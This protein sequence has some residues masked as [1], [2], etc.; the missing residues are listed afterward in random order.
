[1]PKKETTSLAEARPDL[2]AEWHPSLNGLV[3][4]EQVLAKSTKK[5]WW[6]CP[7]GD[8][9]EWEARVADRFKRGCHV[10]NGFKVVK[11][12]CLATLNPKLSSEWHPIKNGHRTPFDFSPGSNKKVWW[13]CPEGDDHEWKASIKLRRK[14]GC[15]V[16]AGKMVVNS[17]CLATTNPDL[18]ADWHPSK[19]GELTP[20]D[21][22]EGSDKKVWWK[23]PEGDDHEWE[24]TLKARSIGNGCSVCHGLTV[25]NSNCL[26]TTNPAKAAHWH[27]TKNGDFTPYDFTEFSQQ[28]VWWKC[29]EADDHEWELSIAAKKSN[30][31]PFCTGRLVCSSNSLRTKNAELT[32]QWHATKNGSLTPDDVTEFSSKKIW[33]KCPEGLDHEWEATVYNRKK[34]GCPMCYGKLVSDDNNLEVVAPDLAALWHPTKNGDLKP[35]DVTKGTMRVVWWKCPEGDDHEWKGPVNH[36]YSNFLRDYKTKGCP[37]CSGY[38][39]VESTSLAKVNPGLAKEWHTVKNG[40]TTPEQVSYFSSKK[41][42]WQCQIDPGHFW[43]STVRDR[44]HGSKCPYCSLTPQSKQEL[45]ISF[46]LKS[47]FHDINPKGFKS[48][49]N[50]KLWTIDIYIPSLN[51]GIEFDGSF[52]HKDKRA[53]DKIKT[54]Q[55]ER[56]GFKIIRIREAPLKKINEY[57][58]ISEVPFSPKNLVNNLLRMIRTDYVLPKSRQEEISLYLKK[59]R[60]QNTE[61][62]EEYITSVLQAKAERKASDQA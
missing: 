10:C 57:D 20:F 11:S 31:C 50:N 3:T 5:Y 61:E 15:P 53:L 35:T 42:W 36:L 44:H 12:N 1:M 25:V 32:S 34:T 23:C 22:T 59:K 17:N 52:W 19:N 7:E 43:R 30:S 9:H 51:L 21:V 26:A 14:T 58:I 13:K 39:V 55:L 28:K 40:K 62:L 4:P 6:K 56:A 48:R 33:W 54:E 29:P 24:A 49:I 60:L 38:Q 27:P 46:E 18:A 16:C 8:D 37:M 45:T 41:S 47:I 2:A